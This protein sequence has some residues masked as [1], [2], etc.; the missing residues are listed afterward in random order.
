MISAYQYTD[1][2]AELW[3]GWHSRLAFL[4]GSVPGRVTILSALVHQQRVDLGRLEAKHE[5][6]QELTV[7]R[8]G[9]YNDV[10]KA[11]Y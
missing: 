3:P 8:N 4:H 6:V 11:L 1:D 2:P 10:S 9:Y 5:E 7:C